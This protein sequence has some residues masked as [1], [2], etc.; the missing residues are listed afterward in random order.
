MKMTVAL[1]DELLEL[2]KSYTGLTAP[3]EVIREALTALIQR[4]SAR[5]L[6]M[7]GGDGTSVGP[8]SAS[9]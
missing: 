7:L 8:D 6:V 1:D 4:E 3:T 9:P 5:R 2:A